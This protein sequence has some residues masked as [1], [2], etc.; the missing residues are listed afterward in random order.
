MS[1]EQVLYYHK[2]DLGGFTYKVISRDNNKVTIQK[3]AQIPYKKTEKYNQSIITTQE[4]INNYVLCEEQ[5][6]I[7]EAIRKSKVTK[8]VNPP[9]IDKRYNKF[10][11]T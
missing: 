3:M 7:V 1:L 6:S 8:Q 10:K 4:F 5:D 9:M 2:D 11:A